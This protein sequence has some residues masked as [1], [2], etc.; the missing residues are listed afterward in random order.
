[1]STPAILMVHCSVPGTHHCTIEIAG[2]DM[3]VLRPRMT[4]PFAATSLDH[5]PLRRALARC[6]FSSRR[7]PRCWHLGWTLCLFDLLVRAAAGGSGTPSTP[8]AIARNERNCRL[9]GL[10]AAPNCS[11]PALSVWHAVVRGY[12]RC[13]LQLLLCQFATTLIVVIAISGESVWVRGCPILFLMLAAAA[14]RSLDRCPAVLSLL[15]Q[16]LL[17]TVVML[18]AGRVQNLQGILRCSSTVVWLR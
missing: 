11:G 14:L 15:Q 16:Q 3:H 12:E 18:Q 8:I 13:V 10:A 17:L 4:L 1:M 2:V 5:T 6:S 7:P 9:C